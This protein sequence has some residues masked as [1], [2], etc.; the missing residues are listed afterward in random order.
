MALLVL[1]FRGGLRKAHVL[2]IEFMAVQGHPRSLISVPIKSA[3]ATFLINSNVGPI[4]PRLRD[5]ARFL[6]KQILF[7]TPP[8]FQLKF[9]ELDDRCWDSKARHDYPRSL[10]TCEVAQPKWLR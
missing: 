10:I 1:N 3:Y 5:I 7:H 6:L 4:L 2:S 8:L 9:E